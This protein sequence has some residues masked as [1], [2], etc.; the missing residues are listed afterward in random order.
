LQAKNPKNGYFLK[1][2]SGGRKTG[3]SEPPQGGRERP[4]KRLGGGSEE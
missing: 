2:F 4:G 1:F 3:R